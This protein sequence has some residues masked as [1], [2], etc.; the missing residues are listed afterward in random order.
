MLVGVGFSPDVGERRSRHIECRDVRRDRKS[1]VGSRVERRTI[2][3]VRRLAMVPSV[4]GTDRCD[5]SG[6]PVERTGRGR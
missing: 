6:Q 3:V 5:F 2:L 4:L 1:A